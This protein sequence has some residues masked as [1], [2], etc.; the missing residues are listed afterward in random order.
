MSFDLK[1]ALSKID[2]KPRISVSALETLGIT[3]QE[4]VLRVVHPELFHTPASKNIW[5]ELEGEYPEFLHFLKGSRAQFAAFPASG[6][7]AQSAAIAKSVPKDMN[8]GIGIAHDPGNNIMVHPHISECFQMLRPDNVSEQDFLKVQNS[9]FKYNNGLGT[10]WY[11]RLAR[12][13]YLQDG[14]ADP[15][16]HQ[17]M[18]KSLGIEPVPGYGGTGN[19]S[20]AFDLLLGPSTPLVFPVTYW[21]NMNLKSKLSSLRVIKSDF[22]NSSG[23]I[24]VS[25]LRTSL[26]ELK[27]S[28]YKKAG[29]YFNYPHNPTGKVPTK[30][31]AGEISTVLQDFASSD[32]QIVAVC[33]EPYYPFQKGK[34]SIEVPFSYY[35]QPG[36][37]R[38]LITV[39]SINGT[40][41]DGL[42]GLR[43][44]D[45][46]FLLPHGLSDNC[47]K[48]L[49]KDLLAGYIRGQYSFSNALNQYLLARCL[50][51]DAL[52]AIKNPDEL[53]LD[54]SYAQK[55]AELKDQVNSRVEETAG[56][57]A[58]CELIQRACK[59]GELA[60][61]GFFL[62]YFLSDALVQKGIT[63]RD[64]HEL[65]L[66]KNCGVIASSDYL[67]I[68][69]LLP[70]GK[71][72]E[73]ASNLE[74]VLE[75]LTR[76]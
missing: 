36:E 76:R 40:K 67:R 38:N 56:R 24:E 73:F 1:S 60:S 18:Q 20:L 7:P 51:G 70:E 37:N 19:L 46:I 22:Q 48:V 3:E 68:N 27:V 4:Q 39:V 16:L 6:I 47:L 30:T 25:N 45:L 34:E 17:S 58:Q 66:K 35:L 50:S 32:F 13:R 61:G 9:V 75:E 62:S 69:A 55:E 28:G 10:P 44:G 14:K 2:G 33:D 53:S 59:N 65:G 71:L 23:E 74:S 26:E 72:E 12:L 8:A 41:R 31:Q 5:K 11:R 54:S 42:Y 52:C 21:G 49:E 63:P 15:Q 43:H 64:V 57:L 29:V